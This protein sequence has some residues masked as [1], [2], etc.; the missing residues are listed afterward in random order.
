[1]SMRSPPSSDTTA[2]TREPFSPTQAPT[3]SIDSSRLYTAI[4]VRPPTSRA[5]SRISTIPW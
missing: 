4:F 2:W 5:I 1:M 3:G